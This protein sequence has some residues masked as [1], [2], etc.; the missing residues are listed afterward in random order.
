[1]TVIDYATGEVIESAPANLV[2]FVPS[3]A[4]ERT[5]Q[6]V[7]DV[8]TQ[9]RDWLASAVEMTGPAEIAQAKA[10]IVSAATYAKELQLSKEIQ[11]DGTEMVR[12]AEYALGRA[13][14][15][16]QA[17][18]TVATRGGNGSNAHQSKTTPTD[19]LLPSP[20]DFANRG[21]LYGGGPGG[22]REGALGI[23]A[24]ADNVTPEQFEEAIEAAKDEGNLSRANVVRKVRDIK[25][26]GPETRDQRARKITELAQQG[27]S[28]R[29]IAPLVGITEESVTNIIRDYGIDVP[30]DR[31]VKKTRRINPAEVIEN[32]IGTIDAATFSLGHIAPGAVQGEQIDSLIQ[33]INALRKAANKIKESL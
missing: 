22:P 9:A 3:S 15:K 13:I 16:G 32:V 8:L 2:P 23:Y 26:G 31:V 24:M 19:I 25:D 28:T 18:G 7:V 4:I 21:E 12:R 29:Q 30:A 14:R 33:S 20:L 6:G 5:A 17:E 11:A 27:Y 1:M 10:A